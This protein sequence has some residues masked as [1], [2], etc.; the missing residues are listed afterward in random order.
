MWETVRLPTE[1]T[2]F[3]GKWYFSLTQFLTEEVFLKHLKAL[4]SFCNNGIFSFSMFCFNFEGHFSEKS[5]Q[6][7]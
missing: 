2:A 1:V 3:W 5:S 4:N 7:C 6:I